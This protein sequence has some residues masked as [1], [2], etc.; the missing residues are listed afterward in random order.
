MDGETAPV[1]KLEP[2]VIIDGV[3]VGEVLHKGG[4]AIIYD[5]KKDGVD[6]PLLLKVPRLAHGED[7]AAIVGFEMEMMIL[8]R[9]S[10][11][12]VPKVYAVGDFARAPY[13]L[14]ER[15]EGPSLYAKLDHLPLPPEEVA[16][17]GASVAHALASL[18]RQHVIHFDIK[19]SNILFRPSGEAVLID[20]GLSHHAELPDLIEEEFRLPYGTAPYM[21]P[22]QVI[23]VRAYRRSDIFALGCLMYFFATGVR[24]FGDPQSVAGLKRR[25]WDDPTPPRALNKA[26]PLWLQEIILRCLEP[27]PEDRPPTAAQ[28][29]FDL[30]HP[31]QV[32]L[33][34]RAHKLKRDSWL[35]R[36]KRKGNEDILRAARKK[37][38]QSKLNAAP[39]IAVAVDSREPEGAMAEA[40]RSAIVRAWESNPEARIALLNVLKQKALGVDETH[41]ADGRPKHLKRLVSLQHW[42]AP[43]RMPD[44]RL[45][46]HVLEAVNPADAI[47]EYARVNHVDHIIMGARKESVQRRVL[48]SVSAEVAGHAPCTVTVV[49]A[50]ETARDY[51]ALG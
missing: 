45:T 34:A 19:P 3:T 5:A 30:R 1:T 37:A 4:M 16:A 13:I 28:L 20:F 44:G 10:G 24:P 36:H 47:L 41:D 49:R 18:H 23:G 17:M 33:T 42:A 39:I 14:M 48:G 32:A 25:L 26:I 15:L 50:R 9:L 2:G 22:E 7:S 51:D 8:P 29:A 38:I 43:M 6:A 35:A 12:H 46:Y 11:P 21:A 31:E 27:N 40:M